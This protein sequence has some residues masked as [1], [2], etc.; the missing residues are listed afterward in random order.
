MLGKKWKMLS[1]TRRNIPFVK[2]LGK[3]FLIQRILV[4]AIV[5]LPEIPISF[6]RISREIYIPM[7]NLTSYGFKLSPI[8]PSRTAHLVIR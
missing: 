5:T 7:K 8:H 4:S 3:S 2:A 6:V 1:D